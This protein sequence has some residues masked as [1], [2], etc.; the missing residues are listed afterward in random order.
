MHQRGPG[1]EG[2]AEP[3]DENAEANAPEQAAT[4]QGIMNA[5]EVRAGADRR[6][7][8][9]D[10]AG[11]RRA[12]MLFGGGQQNAQ[13]RASEAGSPVRATGTEKRMGRAPGS[14]VD[15]TTRDEFTNSR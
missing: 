13:A 10:A 8:D 3:D 2:G 7:L 12:V 11:S 14:A 1:A 6:G 9:T 15:L 5:D 4:C